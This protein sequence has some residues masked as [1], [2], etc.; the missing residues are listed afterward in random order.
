[1]K[2]TGVAIFQV[3]IMFADIVG[4]TSLAKRLPPTRVMTF[5]NELY[6]AFDELVAIYGVYKVS[7]ILILELAYISD[8]QNGEVLRIQCIVMRV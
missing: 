8:G 1:M 4:F 7:P 3:T 6:S 2:C 5:L